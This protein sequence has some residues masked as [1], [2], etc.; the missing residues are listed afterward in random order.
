MES[1]LWHARRF[2]ENI[3]FCLQTK[4]E[5]SL[6]YKSFEVAKIFV[7]NFEDHFQKVV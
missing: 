6:G 1:F 3:S 5:L 4:R 7:D 2:A